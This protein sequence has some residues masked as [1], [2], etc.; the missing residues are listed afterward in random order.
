MDRLLLGDSSKPS[1]DTMFWVG[2]DPHGDIV[3]YGGMRFP[4]EWPGVA[5]L[6]RTGV[7]SEHRGQGLQKRLIRARVSHAVKCGCRSV[8]TYT[9]PDNAAS[10]NSLIS[11]GFKVYVPTTQYVGDGYVYWIKILGKKVS[12]P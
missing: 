8:V 1:N 7:H 10:A 4:P 12:S 6:S 2:K 11:C 9:S 3:A 5:F